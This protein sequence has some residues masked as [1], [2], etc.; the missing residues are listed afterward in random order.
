M[1]A[2]APLVATVLHVRFFGKVYPVEITRRMELRGAMA[3]L[4]QVVPGDWDDGTWAMFGLAGEEDGEAWCAADW[5]GLKRRWIEKVGEG[6]RA[7]VVM[8]GA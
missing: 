7:W 1:R 5:A 8:K 4:K 3:A 2:T 6:E